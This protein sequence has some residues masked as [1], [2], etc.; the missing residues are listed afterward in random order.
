MTGSEAWDHVRLTR[1]EPP[2]AAKTGGRAAL[3][4]AALQQSEDLMRAAEATGRAARPLPLFYSLSQAGKAIEACYG[5]EESKRHGL[6]LFGA[7]RGPLLETKIAAVKPEGRFQSVSRCL[8]SQEP[9]KEPTLGDL[10]ASLPELASHLPVDTQRPRP[11][12]VHIVEPLLPYTQV[13]PDV[14]NVHIEFDGEP[15]NIDTALK[16]LLEH[17][18]DVT[19]RINVAPEGGRDVVGM[20][21]S[22]SAMPFLLNVVEPTNSARDP[23]RISF[24][25]P[26]RSHSFEWGFQWGYSLR[27]AVVDVAGERVPNL[28]MTWWLVLFG[29]S[30]F[31]RYHPRE[32]VEALNVD[33]SLVA[34]LLD[35]CMSEAMDRVPTLV[36]D[37]IRACP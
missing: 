4:R 29:L 7:I 1:L 30:M 15:E 37:A 25:T 10:L 22:S 12:H 23:N 18:P 36:L 8:K 26:Y 28:L 19:G 16:I 35:R 33:S 24:L 31:A 27:P 3:Y 34:V 21:L 14:V 6:T 13:L 17:Y 11:L 9:S 20:G 5:V 2:G 32:W